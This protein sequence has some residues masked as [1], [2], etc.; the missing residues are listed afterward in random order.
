MIGFTGIFASGWIWPIG[1]VVAGVFFVLMLHRL[2]EQCAPENR[3]LDAN[4][5]WLLFVPIFNLYWQFHVARKV[6][7]SLKKEYEARD[8]PYSNGVTYSL[9]MALASC[10]A[11][12]AVLFWSAVG[13]MIGGEDDLIGLNGMELAGRIALGVSAFLAVVMLVLWIV[14]WAK[15]NGLSKELQPK[16]PIIP[17]MYPPLAQP[18]MPMQPMSFQPQQPIQTAP[19]AWSYQNPSYGGYQCSPQYVP[20]AASATY[21]PPQPTGRSKLES[22][23]RYCSRCGG[24]LSGGPYCTWCGA[25]PLSGAKQE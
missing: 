11:I 21:A 16:K 2:L 8:L 9:G 18:M 23:P 24:T 13:L 4:L 10:S 5:V 15:L 22:P 7:S 1:V 12:T 20:P 6:A 19:P 3:R 17:A 14:Y 25:E